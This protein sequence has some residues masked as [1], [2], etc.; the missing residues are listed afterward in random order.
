MKEVSHK[1][2]LYDPIF[3]KFPEQANLERQK[4]DQWFPRAEQNE[5]CRLTANG[6][7][8]LLGM[9]KMFQI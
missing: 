8:F 4:G 7:G 6:Q 2:I 5:E 3:M 9:I 1:Y